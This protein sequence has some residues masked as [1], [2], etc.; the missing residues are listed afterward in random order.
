MPT[1]K[2]PYRDLSFILNEVLDYTK[3]YASLSSGLKA[4][5]DIVQAIIE[6]SAKFCEKILFPLNAKGDQQGCIKS[7]DTV[8]T[9]DGFKEAY[10][11]FVKAGW[12]TL[13]HAEK[14]GGQGMPESLSLLVDEMMATAN[15]AWSM[16]PFLSHGAK[17]TLKTHGSEQQQQIYLP[18]LVS[19]Q[20][21]GTMCLT[22]PQCGT[23]LNLVK[24][25]AISN[26]Q[27]NIYQINGEK[28]YISSG[29]HDLSENIIHIVLARLPDAPQDT[30][31][32]SL[33]IVPKFLVS[34]SSE[35][36][37]RNTVTCTGIEDKMGIH[38][39]ATCSMLFDNATGYLLGEPNKGLH[40]MFT[41]M[42][43]ARLGTGIQ[44]L[45]HSE[46]A[47]QNA[48]SYTRERLAMRNLKGAICPDKPAD[49]ILTHPDVRR[50]LLTIRALNEGNRALLYYAAYWLDLS[51]QASKDNETTIQQKANSILEFLT[52]IVKAFLTETGFESAN[53]GL[54]CFGGHGYIKE[55]G[56]EQNLRDSRIATLYEGTTGIQALDLLG[57]KV[58]LNKGVALKLFIGEIK[59]FCKQAS[60]TKAVK[61]MIQQVLT[62]CSQWEK[63]SLSIGLKALKNKEEVSAAAYD[64]LMFSGYVCLA[65]FWTKMATIAHQA[66]ANQSDDIN[67]YQ[68]KIYTAEFYFERLLPRANMHQQCITSG[69]KN[70][71][72][73]LNIHF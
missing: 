73:L 29:E 30:K 40:Y 5:P 17:K 55:W 19:G 65:F 33:F 44:G 12:P 2:A 46:Y 31:G 14:F 48:L 50:M 49:P 58:L 4:S 52:P 38:G 53:L 37:A 57:R 8:K 9:P 28:I 61:P 23:D 59:S 71:T 70:L 1:Y 22:E 47:Y 54:Q 21:T 13:S 10:T 6:E 39:N 24:T 41:F 27:N 3:H 72:Q 26:T 67:F 51:E 15:W 43:I 20:W 56:M 18:K 63:L 45:A 35:L 62:L 69:A 16:Y 25:S 42:N 68:G 36:L 66:I 34:E 64:Y 32:L 60:K 11:A 7:G